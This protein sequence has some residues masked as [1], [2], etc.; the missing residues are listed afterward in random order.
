MKL[1][2]IIGLKRLGYLAVLLYFK[3]DIRQWLRVRF[4]FSRWPTLNG[5]H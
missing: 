5:S 4:A 2:S 1:A 3:R